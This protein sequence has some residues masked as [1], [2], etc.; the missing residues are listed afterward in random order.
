MKEVKI[1]TLIENQ[2]IDVLVIEKDGRY[3]IINSGCKKHWGK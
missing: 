1:L 2:P 3:S